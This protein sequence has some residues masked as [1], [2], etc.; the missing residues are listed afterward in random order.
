[1]QDQRFWRHSV[2]LAGAALSGGLVHSSHPLRVF[3]SLP[4]DSATWAACR[5]VLFLFGVSCVAA[6]RVG[7][8]L[9]RRRGGSPSTKGAKLARRL[10]CCANVRGTTVAPDEA[11]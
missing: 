10:V 1:M 5:Y 3:A 4:L 9:R 6:F 8:V 11:L 7:R 2:F